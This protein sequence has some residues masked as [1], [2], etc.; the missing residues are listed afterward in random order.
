M[1]P[2]SYP[3]PPAG[4]AWRTSIR[5]QGQNGC[6]EVAVDPSGGRWLRDTKDR[7]RPAHFFTQFEWDLFIA[8]AKDGEFD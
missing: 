7:T 3:Q 6:V 4:L 5:S 2:T 1:T 8:G